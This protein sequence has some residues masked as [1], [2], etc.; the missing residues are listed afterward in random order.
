[1]RDEARTGV[2]LLGRAT[3]RWSLSLATL[4]EQD[5]DHEHT[6][7][8]LSHGSG[9]FCHH[10]PH[11]RDSV[12]H[13]SR[14][15]GYWADWRFWGLSKTQ[16][17]NVHINVGLLFLLA[18]LLH[19]YYNWKPITTYLKNKS[20]QMKI[21]TKEMNV[22]LVLTLVFTVGTLAEAPPFSTILDFSESIKEAASRKYGEPPWGHAELSPIS[23][24]AKK[25]GWQPEA[26]IAAL[27]DAGYAV[28][29]PKDTV[30][31]IAARKSVPPQELYLSL[32]QRLQ[33]EDAPAG[34]LPEAPPAGFGQRSLQEIAATYG[35]PLQP[36]IDALK[37]RG[38]DADPDTSL[39]N[40]AANSG[41]NPF[42]LFEIIKVA[43]ENTT[44]APPA[45][46]GQGKN[47][48]Q[49]AGAGEQPMGLGRMSLEEVLQQY[50]I[51]RQTAEARLKELGIEPDMQAKL[52]PL[53]ESAGITPMDLFNTLKGGSQ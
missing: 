51:D 13:P 21:F 48:G 42:E 53:A 46:P 32:K 47:Q 43:T 23:T 25:M 7:H 27:K 11:Q 18:L 2:Q 19:A 31:E 15:G 40:L 16:W 26:T 20:R 45:K 50:G 1:M 34:A 39:K 9:Q 24:F 17:G 33:T 6:P 22:A 41:G 35:V 38:V 37:A 49:T 36:M 52:R 14:P 29:S 30:A 28:E 3:A 5:T 8:H 44:A 4:T 10:H 12:H